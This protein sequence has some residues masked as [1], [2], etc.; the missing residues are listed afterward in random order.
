MRGERI[1]IKLTRA[2]ACGGISVFIGISPVLQS[3]QKALE[4]TATQGA[5]QGDTQLDSD[6]MFFF[7]FLKF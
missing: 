5:K 4:L 7:F 1:G 3:T 2:G 6:V